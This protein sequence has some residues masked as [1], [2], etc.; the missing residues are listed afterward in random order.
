LGRSGNS[1]DEMQQWW[2]HLVHHRAASKK[3]T[4][5]YHTTHHH[6]SPGAEGKCF[7]YRTEPNMLWYCGVV[8]SGEDAPRPCLENLIVLEIKT[9]KQTSICLGFQYERVSC[10]AL[11]D[12]LTL[13]LT[14]PIDQHTLQCSLPSL[15][16]SSFFLVSVDR[17]PI[18]K[19][20][21]QSRVGVPSSSLNFVS[22]AA[23]VTGRPTP[24]NQNL[25]P[26]RVRAADC[27]CRTTQN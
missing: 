9:N 8:M 18:S 13:R 2:L 26:D 16:R 1:T 5:F 12:S 23:G 7:T 27:S 20:W 21:P 10:C 24:R 3:V 25:R 6:H 22:L 15:S 4:F 11:S 19:N 17:T 14:V